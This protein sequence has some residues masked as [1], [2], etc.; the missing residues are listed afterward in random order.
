MSELEKSAAPAGERLRIVGVALAV[1]FCLFPAK[2][3][4]SK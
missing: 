1:R 4:I 3:K 2:P